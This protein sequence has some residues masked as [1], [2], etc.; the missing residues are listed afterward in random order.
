MRDDDKILRDVENVPE[1]RRKEA[2][3]T[4]QERELNLASLSG[5]SAIVKAARETRYRILEELSSDWEEGFAYRADIMKPDL[6]NALKRK[7]AQFWFQHQRF[8]SHRDVSVGT[9]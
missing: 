5:D 1:E 7:D 6:F 9:V 3:M 4:I 8:R 2:L